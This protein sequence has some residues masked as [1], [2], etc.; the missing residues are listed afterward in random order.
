MDK[1]LNDD[2]PLSLQVDLIDIHSLEIRTLTT[3]EI[4]FQ[5]SSQTSIGGIIISLPPNFFNGLLEKKPPTSCAAR[6]PNRNIDIT[7]TF[8][9]E[10]SNIIMNMKSTERTLYPMR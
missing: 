3:L 8:E 5:V 10:F 6:D 9:S 7:T 1:V 2:A 4:L